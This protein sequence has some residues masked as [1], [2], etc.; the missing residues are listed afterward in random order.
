MP[1]TRCKHRSL[2]PGKLRAAIPA[3]SLLALP[4]AQRYPEPDT[5][6]SWRMTQCQGGPTTTADPNPLR[7]HFQGGCLAAWF[8]FA[9]LPSS[10]C[11]AHISICT[12]K[13]GLRC[14]SQHPAQHSGLITFAIPAVLPT[15][16]EWT[17][18]AAF[19]Q[20]KHVPKKL[21]LHRG[22]PCNLPGSVTLQATSCYR[23]CKMFL[24][25]V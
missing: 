18:I 21:P 19:F 22:C 6:I 9:P 13:R 16:K 12:A 11:C 10:D 24:S 23:Q 1:A 2:Q 5:K 17:G 20:S 15:S 3:S 4:T 8:G 7:P 25:G 14:S